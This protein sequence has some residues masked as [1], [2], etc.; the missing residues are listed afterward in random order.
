MTQRQAP[1]VVLA[2]VAA[3]VAGAALASRPVAVVLVGLSLGAGVA[4]LLLTRTRRRLSTLLERSRTLTRARGRPRVTERDPAWRSLWEA[5]DHAGDQLRSRVDE[6]AAERARV[7]GILEGLPP[8]ILLFGDDGLTYANTAARKLFRLDPGPFDPGSRLTPMQV[9]GVQVLADAVLHTRERGVDEELEAT[10]EDRAFFAR[11]SRTA[12]GEIALVMTDLT[13]ARRLD[14]V[15]RDFV[16]NASH[17]LK[18]PVAGVQALADSLGLAAAKDPER[19][20]RMISR[21]QGEASRLATLV[22]ELLDLARVEELGDARPTSRVDLSE[23][24]TSQVERLR[25]AADE[26]SVTIVA[27]VSGPCWVNATPEDTRL[28]VDNLVQNAVRY[29]RRGGSVHVRVTANAGRVL[30]EVTDT[31][32]GIPEA[33][34]ERVFERFYRVDKARSRAA[35]GTGLGLSLVR[36]ATGRLGGDVSLSSVLGEGSTFRVDLTGAEVTDDEV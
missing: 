15:R 20:V 8:A 26:R 28:I 25:P 10:R 5:L 30:L 2:V 14:A 13:E 34:R 6:L 16:T 9:L 19:A 29:N 11:T 18:T 22:R 27:S 3:A 7:I 33:D 35:G 17:E 21:M 32:I 4:A 24:V 12:Q 31:G 36:H 23:V 1:L